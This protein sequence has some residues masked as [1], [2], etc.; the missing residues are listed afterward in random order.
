MALN[1]RNEYNY[2]NDLCDKFINIQLEQM[3]EIC[4]LCDEIMKIK[5]DSEEDPEMYKEILSIFPS[6][7]EINLSIKYLSIL[8]QPR[9]DGGDIFENIL[10]EDIESLA[11]DI[12]AMD[13]FFKE[14]YYKKTG[15]FVKELPKKYIQTLD[16]CIKLLNM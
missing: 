8:L 5:I 2:V 4:D 9:I 10:Y 16:I 13:N 12:I 11:K 3:E 15:L 1:H 6:Y 14:Q 7:E